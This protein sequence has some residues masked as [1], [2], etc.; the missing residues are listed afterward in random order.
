M[1]T[2]KRK[3]PLAG[4][5]TAVLLGIL[6]GGSSVAIEQAW[7]CW[8][9]PSEIIKG[10]R[11]SIATYAM[12]GFAFGGIVGGIGGVLAGTIVL[13]RRLDSPTNT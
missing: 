9:Y 3:A 2:A 7:E 11:T 12:N 5:L 13:A 10:H 4:F 1:T 8:N 6:L